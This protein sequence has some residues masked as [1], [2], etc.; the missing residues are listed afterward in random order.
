MRSEAEIKEA[1]EL[2][3]SEKLTGEENILARDATVEALRWALGID[4]GDTSPMT[5]SF[6]EMV[7][8]MKEDRD[9]NQSLQE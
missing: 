5:C 6:A 1:I 4:D 3:Q 2:C 7:K 9:S 8:G